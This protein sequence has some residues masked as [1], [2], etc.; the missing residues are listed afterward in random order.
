MRCEKA[1][2]WLSPFVDGELG[3]RSRSGVEKHLEGCSSC[4][5]YYLQIKMDHTRVNAAIGTLRPE[6]E[7]FSDRM[8]DMILTEEPGS[9]DLIQ[10]DH[11]K[12]PFLGRMTSAMTSRP[13][14]LLALAAS[15][16]LVVTLGL[17]MLEGDETASPATEIASASNILDREKDSPQE[18]KTLN[19]ATSLSSP[20]ISDRT[21]FQRDQQAAL[22][23]DSEV[24]ISTSDA[25]ADL[26]GESNE[27]LG[28]VQRL[29]A[30]VK[31]GD[32]E[33][34]F[35]IIE[36]IRGLQDE[37]GATF[38]ELAKQMFDESLDPDVREAL[39][40]ALGALP[41]ASTIGFLI[42]RLN[43]ENS[44][45]VR[46]AILEVLSSRPTLDSTHLFL[47]IL[48]NELDPKVRMSAI[49]GLGTLATPEALVAIQN[50]IEDPQADTEVRLEALDTLSEV[51]D[52]Q[53][54]N[55]PSHQ[56][57]T[58]LNTLERVVRN[59][60]ENFDHRM[61][62]LKAIAKMSPHKSQVALDRLA[63]DRNL[64]E[65]ITFKAHKIIK[66]A[67]ER[68]GSSSRADRGSGFEE[69]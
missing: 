4:F 19:R 2:S 24:M 1:R 34:G 7:E 22:D 52:N 33:L 53:E 32:F 10:L 37:S 25:E 61:S 50:E 65:D 14:L 18:R 66:K 31:N 46:R 47:E 9:A 38:L 45:P 51:F 8:T 36:Q 40:F 17:R 42:D 21:D 69:E 27:P 16:P 28:L 23:S 15:L 6:V 3:I 63:N 13:G 68:L 35:A 56:E 30:A 26:E 49:R 62:A 57:E 55:E 39:I 67:M 29:I 44:I 58:L 54:P 5:S 20:S 64:P 43:T 59:N 11:V 60:S 48:A 41:G 12:A